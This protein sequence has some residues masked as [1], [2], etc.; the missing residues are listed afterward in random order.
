M[1]NKFLNKNMAHHRKDK[2]CC[3]Q[4]KHGVEFEPT[5]VTFRNMNHNVS[6]PE[7]PEM[8]IPKPLRDSECDSPQDE[9]MSLYLEEDLSKSIRST[10]TDIVDLLGT[11][12][13][14]NRGHNPTL[15]HAIQTALSSLGDLVTV[16]KSSANETDSDSCDTFVLCVMR[17]VNGMKAS[18]DEHI[19]SLSVADDGGGVD[20]GKDYMPYFDAITRCLADHGKS[21]IS[22][23]LA[24]VNM[25]RQELRK[26][27][28]VVQRHVRESVVHEA[29]RD[30]P[31]QPNLTSPS[32]T[33]NKAKEDA[34]HVLDDIGM[35]RMS[36]LQDLVRK[37][38]NLQNVAVAAE[39]D[40]PP[41]MLQQ[42][43]M[44]HESELME[45]HF[46]TELMR[47]ELQRIRDR[48]EAEAY[49]A[50]DIAIREHMIKREEAERMMADKSKRTKRTNMLRADLANKT[51]LL[52]QSERRRAKER[53]RLETEHMQIAKQLND[54]K[55]KEAYLEG[56]L[57]T[58]TSSAQL[59]SLLDESIEK[60]KELRKEIE[61]LENERRRAKSGHALRQN[62]CRL[63]NN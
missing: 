56:R 27:L 2:Y 59:Q 34:L 42:L 11:Q 45:M 49:R 23:M 40:S 30:F 54:A 36:A 8:Y 6:P 63:R 15:A 46:Q 16:I 52:K 12:V 31:E 1:A 38:Q 39:L 25:N 3:K 53:A 20:Y 41:G 5:W 50:K 44:D 24:D 48:N 10:I 47:A 43:R 4:L 35:K 17:A 26:N 60:E 18:A 32:H 29:I 21:C 7:C 14:V 55:Q 9:P 13:Y 22:D 37:V 19:G 58:Q 62:T 57:D 33:S 61:L 28:G 51:K